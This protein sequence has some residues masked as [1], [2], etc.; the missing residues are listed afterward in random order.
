MININKKPKSINKGK[1]MITRINSNKFKTNEIGIFLTLPL[2]K[3]T[4]TMNA[5]IPQ[6]LRRGTNTYKT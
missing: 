4:I 1:E 2:N 5:L 3:K 6:V